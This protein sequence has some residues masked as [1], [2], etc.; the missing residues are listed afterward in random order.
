MPG[1]LARNWPLLGA[2]LKQ[3]WLLLSRYPVN[4]IANFSLVLV[5]VVG[6]TVAVSLFAPA[7]AGAALD[8]GRL[9]LYGFAIYLFLS[10]SLWT[11][12]LGVQRERLQGTLESLYLSPAP[13]PLS[14]AARALLGWGWTAVAAAIGLGIAQAIIGRVP[15]HQPGLALLILAGILGQFLGL[16]LVLAGLGLLLGESVELLSNLLEFGL[17]A[18]CAFFF[19]FSVLPAPVQ[20]IS[21]LIPLSYAVDAF[22]TALL[23]FPSG[24]PELGSFGVE[25]ALV[26]AAGLLAPVAG[27]GLYALAERRL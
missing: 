20:V 17:L 4:L 22:R 3:Q 7:E 16:G 24:Y 25:L 26:L 15:F 23:G 14:L 5:G 2:M 6:L 9:A 11:I 13:R 10:G 21:R 12:G 27:Y 8:F 19:P 18:L 1:R